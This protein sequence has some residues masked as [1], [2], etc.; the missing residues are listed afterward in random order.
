MENLDF[1]NN[2]L[3]QEKSTTLKLLQNMQLR[4]KIESTKKKIAELKQTLDFTQS[5]NLKLKQNLN[6]LDPDSA[7]SNQNLKPNDVLFEDLKK[8]REIMRSK[9]ETTKSKSFILHY[10][11]SNMTILESLL[12]LV[13]GYLLSAFFN[14]FG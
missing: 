11:F 7:I 2:L 12:V 3:I 14:N 4:L 5:E 1:F 6:I 9:L 8:S 13:F 10:Q